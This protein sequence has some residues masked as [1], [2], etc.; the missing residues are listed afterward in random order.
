MKTRLWKKLGRGFSANNS[1][2]RHVVS[3]ST[4]QAQCGQKQKYDNQPT[5]KYIL[6][7]A[8]LFDRVSHLNY[9]FKHG[10]KVVY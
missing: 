2:R 8:S 4:P 10:F 3:Y 7:L 6:G 5:T 9:R 1:R